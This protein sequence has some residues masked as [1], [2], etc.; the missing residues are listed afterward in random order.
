LSSAF[1]TT[2][3]DVAREAG[4]SPATVSRA[5][6]NSPLVNERT[7]QRVWEVAE[8]LRFRPNRLASSLRRGATLAVGVVVPDVAARFYAAALKG[9]H[10][11][12]EA[13][14]YHV[15][16]V[17]TERDARR[18]REALDFLRAYQVDGL[19]VATSGGYGDMGVPTVF[20][21]NAA[22]EASAAVLLDNEDGIFQLVWHLATV[23][24]HERIAYV[25]LPASPGAGRERLEGFRAAVGRCGL[26]LPPQYVALGTSDWER[27]GRDLTAA[28]LALEE[29]PT[30]IVAGADLF[31]IGALRAAREVALV[32]FDEPE[33][34]DLLEPSVTSL[35]RHDR[36]L[37]R[38]AAELLLEV[39]GGGAPAGIERVPLSLTVR[40]SCG[41][42]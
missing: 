28:L 1:R 9:V 7:R 36:Q 16:V 35:D 33:F 27:D 26:A 34:A 19:V 31:A 42:E 6:A 41:C 40:R 12:V 37:G 24:G 20:F 23:H 5:L 30:A 39:L 21:D 10:D 3:S 15:L 11:V 22:P 17:N 13:A 2:L 4:V 29:P 8:R 14:G 25:G 32:S 18:E 38:R